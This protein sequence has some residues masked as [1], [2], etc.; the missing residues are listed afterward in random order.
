MR[1]EGRIVGDLAD[2][3]PAAYGELR[4]LAAAKMAGERPDRTLDVTA[5]VHEA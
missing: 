4:R 3:L 1:L 5:L 2:S